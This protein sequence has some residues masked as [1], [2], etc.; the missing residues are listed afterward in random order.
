MYIRNYTTHI[1]KDI[2]PH[3]YQQNKRRKTKKQMDQKE[4]KPL[5]FW[6][7]Q[8]SSSVNKK[9]RDRVPYILFSVG[10]MTSRLIDL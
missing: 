2:E 10:L 6:S 8:T 5:C 1:N 9:I 4:G 3:P 7:Y